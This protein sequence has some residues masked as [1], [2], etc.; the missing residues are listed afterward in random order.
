MRVEKDHHRSSKEGAERK[1]KR[2][3]ANTRELMDGS[4][5]R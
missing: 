3:H 1:K 4:R 5:S 2:E